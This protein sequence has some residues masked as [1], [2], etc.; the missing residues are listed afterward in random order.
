MGE[1]DWRYSAANRTTISVPVTL[2]P[3]APIT[4]VSVEFQPDTSHLLATV[5]A[6]ANTELPQLLSSTLYR[7]GCPEEA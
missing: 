1:C 5:P 7:K 6:P 4:A 3:V 2:L